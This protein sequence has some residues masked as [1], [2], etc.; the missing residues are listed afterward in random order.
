MMTNLTNTPGASAR[1]S[2]YQNWLSQRV[3]DIAV[4]GLTTR[5]A[6]D[7]LCM[8]LSVSLTQ[9]FKLDSNLYFIH[10]LSY[11]LLRF[12]HAPFSSDRLVSHEWRCL[13]YLWRGPLASFGI[14]HVVYSKFHL[15]VI[16]VGLIVCGNVSINN[17]LLQRRI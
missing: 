3:C 5:E 4:R 15:P 13:C 11:S 14:V 9:W 12:L 7:G 16:L 6:T 17:S 1:Q 2:C 8:L 10:L